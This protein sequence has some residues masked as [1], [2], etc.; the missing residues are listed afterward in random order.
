MWFEGGGVT[1]CGAEFFY[2]G[3]AGISWGGLPLTWHHVRLSRSLGLSLF[4]RS[5]RM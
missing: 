4:L 3:A 1:G 2:F 5:L